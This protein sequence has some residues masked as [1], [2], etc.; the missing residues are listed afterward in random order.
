MDRLEG[1]DA[2]R[3]AERMRDAKNWPKWPWL[4]VKRSTSPDQENELGLVHTDDI[5]REGGDPIIL[6]EG[7]AETG[8]KLTSGELIMADSLSVTAQY[9]SVEAMIADGWTGD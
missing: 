2:E 9:E 8:G 7:T 5:D 1:E 4:A 3:E 6:Y